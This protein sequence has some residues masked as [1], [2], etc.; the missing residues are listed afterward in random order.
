[1]TTCLS[2]VKSLLS[3]TRVYFETDKRNSYITLLTVLKDQ[4][5]MVKTGKLH[6]S[7]YFSISALSA[8][9]G[10]LH[11]ENCPG[12]KE[13]KIS[14][15]L[16]GAIKPMTVS[17]PR[18]TPAEIL[19]PFKTPHFSHHP[20]HPFQSWHTTS[21]TTGASAKHKNSPPV[22]LLLQIE[23]TQDM[24]FHALCL[25]QLFKRNFCARKLKFINKSTSYFITKAMEM[26]RHVKSHWS[27]LGRSS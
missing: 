20:F 23:S 24:H 27:Q 14:N 16:S 11:S 19:P 2:P 9:A 17:N 6:A 26:P 18:N 7:R 5:W 1:M 13:K 3:G 25:L 15:H 22:S 8:T 12:T 21:V 4:S 10:C